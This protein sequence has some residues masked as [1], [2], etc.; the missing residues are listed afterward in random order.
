MNTEKQNTVTLDSPLLQEQLQVLLRETFG[1]RVEVVD[2][3]IGN[4]RHDYIVLLMELASPD[5]QVVVKLAGPDAPYN[6]PF[7]RT[8][9]CH[10]LVAKETTIPMPEIFV[11]D[12]SYQKWPWRYLIKSLIPGD[13]WAI[14]L[15]DM[16]V[17]QSADSYR[18]FGNAVAQIHSIQFPSFGELT[19]NGAVQN[20]TTCLPALRVHARQM[21][22]KPHL[23]DIFE[24]VLGQHAHLFADVETANLC[25]EDL[26]KHNILFAQQQ[27]GWQLATVLDFDKGWAGHHETDLARLDLWT[28]MT[29]YEFWQAYQEV[30]A[31][32]PLYPQRRPIYQ[33][34]WCLEVAWEDEKHLADT[35]AVCEE[36]SIPIIET[37]V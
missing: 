8:A 20:G 2:V 21:I 24:N 34:L 18:Q 30:R 22:Q 26:H 11:V 36:L 3:R 5:L 35:R 28:D 9:V 33:L 7:E 31:V 12:V 23:R 6:Y 27:D 16:D 32:D 37:F 25:H 10:Q 13:E 19:T 1:S 4:Q 29:T 15:P 14:V 17:E